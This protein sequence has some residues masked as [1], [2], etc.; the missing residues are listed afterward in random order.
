MKDTGTHKKG[1]NTEHK[2]KGLAQIP[3]RSI[4]YSQGKEIKVFWLYQENRQIPITK[5]LLECHTE[6]NRH[7]GRQK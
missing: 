2:N 1:Q 3:Q 7:R 5:I 4:T 6:G